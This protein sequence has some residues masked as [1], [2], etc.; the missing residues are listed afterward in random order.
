MALTKY[1]IKTTNKSDKLEINK[2]SL[3][4]DAFCGGQS[5]RLLQRATFSWAFSE[6]GYVLKQGAWETSAGEPGRGCRLKHCL[7]FLHSKFN[8]GP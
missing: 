4:C 8:P 2:L 5:E 6:D 7:G 3:S 1:I